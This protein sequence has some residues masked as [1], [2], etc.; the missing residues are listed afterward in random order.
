MKRLNPAQAYWNQRFVLAKCKERLSMLSDA[1]GQQTDLTLYQWAQLMAFALEFSP[2]IILE[3]GRGEGNST[4]AFTEVANLLKPHRCQVLSL[5]LCHSWEEITEP[6]VRKIVPESWFETLIT[7]RTN[8]LY[9]DFKKALDG[10]RRVLVFWDA[11][12][13]DIAECVLGNILPE[14]SDRPHIVIMHDLSDIRYQSDDFNQYKGH[15]LW[16]GNTWDGPR[17]RIGNIDSA[18]EQAV[19]ILDFTTRNKLPL[20]SSDHSFHTEL[21]SD[22]EKLIELKRVLGDELFSLSGHWFWFSLNEIPGPYTFPHFCNDIKPKLLQRLK[23]ALSILRGG[24]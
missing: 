12:G 22:K 19:A 7:L 23:R 15:A 1:V 18:V 9:Y 10:Y 5:C 17:L 16:K 4:C 21:E 2:D 8:I 14:I 11:H 6:R 20:H 3:L 13:F 24:I